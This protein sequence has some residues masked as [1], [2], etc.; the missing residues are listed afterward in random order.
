LHNFCQKH[1]V[2]KMLRHQKTVTFFNVWTFFNAQSH[3]HT[4]VAHTAHQAIAIKAEVCCVRGCNFTIL[5]CI[6]LAVSADLQ[7]LVKI[8]SVPWLFLSSLKCRQPS[9]CRK[10][11]AP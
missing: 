4:R 10:I 3:T 5:A 9:G 11:V 2:S 6:V 7:N 8:T 1:A